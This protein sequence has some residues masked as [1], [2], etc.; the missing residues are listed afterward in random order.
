MWR[1]NPYYGEILDYNST[2]KPPIN[3][4]ESYRGRGIF[5][6]KRKSIQQPKSLELLKIKGKER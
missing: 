1:V 5:G 6:I 2:L 4:Y 3:R